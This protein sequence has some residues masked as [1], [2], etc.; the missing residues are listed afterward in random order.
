MPAKV[1]RRVS[2]CR[3]TTSSPKRSSCEHGLTDKRSRLLAFVT[4][5]RARHRTARILEPV[6]IN[7]SSQRLSLDADFQARQ[8]L[9]KRDRRSKLGHFFNRDGDSKSAQLVEA[10]FKNCS[11]A[12][13]LNLVVSFVA[14]SLHQTPFLKLISP[15]PSCQRPNCKQAG[16]LA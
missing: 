13:W 7:A 8:R 16:H 14:V 6:D 15:F 2:R 1:R 11:F 12:Q 3:L 4:A 9:R 10:Q 5:S